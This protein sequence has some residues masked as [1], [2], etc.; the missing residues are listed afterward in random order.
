MC[1]VVHPLRIKNCYFLAYCAFWRPKHKGMDV[2]PLLIS[3]SLLSLLGGLW[4]MSTYRRVE[5]PAVLPYWVEEFFIGKWHKKVGECNLWKWW[6]LRLWKSNRSDQL[7]WSDRLWNLWTTLSKNHPHKSKLVITEKLQREIC[8][9][10][11]ELILTT[12]S[13]HVALHFQQLEQEKSLEWETLDCKIA[14]ILGNSII[15]LSFVSICILLFWLVVG[16]VFAP[17]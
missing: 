15:L 7:N 2:W 11:V 16:T 5:L 10:L 1:I 12:D 6:L 17:Y 9:S 13:L 14:A 4:W 3:F 8:S